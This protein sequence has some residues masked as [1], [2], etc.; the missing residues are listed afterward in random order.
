MLC[1]RPHIFLLSE[2]SGQVAPKRTSS[3]AAANA[4]RSRGV[5]HDPS[6]THAPRPRASP[7][8]RR[9]LQRSQEQTF[10]HLLI[11]L[12]ESAHARAVVLRELRESELRV[13]S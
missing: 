4:H 7:Q 10:G 13:E 9:V 6:R 1:G 5:S 12:E 3:A 11:D 8:D 2:T